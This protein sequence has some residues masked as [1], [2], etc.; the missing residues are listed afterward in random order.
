MTSLTHRK[1]SDTDLVIGGAGSNLHIR[2]RGFVR[3]TKNRITTSWCWRAKLPADYRITRKYIVFETW[4]GR[5]SVGF[6]AMS[7]DL[8]CTPARLAPWIGSLNRLNPAFLERLLP[9]ADMHET[10]IDFI[11]TPELL[12]VFSSR[13]GEALK[14][15]MERKWKNVWPLR[16]LSYLLES[17]WWS[18][19]YRS[20]HNWLS[21][22]ICR[23]EYDRR[24]RWARI[25]EVLLSTRV[26]DI[27]L[28]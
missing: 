15:R 19:W 17:L 5:G 12:A 6:S 13:Q 24:I 11:S 25:R 10:D 1:P 23:Q 8:V 20:C 4:Q 2:G 21:S 3:R 9:I 16:G 22:H 14:P 27:H 18:R 26:D 7:P 28:P